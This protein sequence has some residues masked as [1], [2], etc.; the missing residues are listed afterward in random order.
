MTGTSQTISG[1]T[2]G[3]DYEFTVT[4]TNE[5]G[6]NTSE[7]RTVKTLAATE[8]LTITRAKWKSNDF[9]VEGT[10]SAS[11][12]TVSV[13]V[14]VTDPLTKQVVPAETPITGM[15]NQPLTAAVAP[16]TGSTFDIR[17]RTNVPNPKPAQ[18]FVKSSNGG[19]AGPFNVANG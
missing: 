12:G 9:R 6:S 19:I 10:S 15:A 17:L 3:T 5:G 16:A 2:A 13:H 8:R 18:I 7:P 4:A 1:L 11:T 14:A